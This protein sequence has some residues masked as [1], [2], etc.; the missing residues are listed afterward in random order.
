M[1]R[2]NAQFMR[3]E[4]HDQY[5]HRDAEGEADD[6]DPCIQLVADQVSEGD[7]KVVLEHGKG[8]PNLWRRDNGPH[9]GRAQKFEVVAHQSAFCPFDPALL[10]A[11]FEPFEEIA[12][13][14]F[15]VIRMR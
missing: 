14:V 12:F 7:E 15:L 5:A 1:E 6:I 2:V 8:C 10:K 13:K 4:K 9:K 3:Y 11:R